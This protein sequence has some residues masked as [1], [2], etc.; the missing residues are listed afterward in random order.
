MTEKYTEIL[1][2]LTAPDQIFAAQEKQHDSGITYREFINTPKTLT[3]FY[4]FGLLFPEWE[5]IVFNDFLVGV[6]FIVKNYE[7]PLRK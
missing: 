7:L 1:N 3:E 4:E 5:F 6:S 2:S